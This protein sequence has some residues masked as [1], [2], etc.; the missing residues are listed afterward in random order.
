[1]SCRKESEKKESEKKENEKLV[2]FDR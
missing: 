2:D 1:M